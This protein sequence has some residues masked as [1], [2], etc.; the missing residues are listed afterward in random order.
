MSL[1]D[2]KVSQQLSMA[3]HP[4]YALIMAAM[5]QADTDNLRKLAREWPG[6]YTEL[7]QRYDAPGGLLFGERPIITEQDVK[8][9]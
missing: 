4:F 1:H 5:R 6:I 2:Y 7:K 8:Y 3:D 9:L